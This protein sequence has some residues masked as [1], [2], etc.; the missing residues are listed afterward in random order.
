MKKKSHFFQDDTRKIGWRSAVG[1]V[2]PN[3]T[4]PKTQ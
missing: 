4:I 1:K 3:T 2:A